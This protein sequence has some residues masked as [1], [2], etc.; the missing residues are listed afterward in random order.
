[1]STSTT[2][3]PGKSRPYDKDLRWRI[4]TEYINHNK[5][6]SNLNM[7][8]ATAQRVFTKFELTGHVDPKSA[9]RSATRCYDEHQELLIIDFT[10]LTV[11]T[12][13]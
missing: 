10:V 12:H 11:T 5:I 8:A 2:A 7:S 9:D 3:E 4:H 1:M 6:A 13:R